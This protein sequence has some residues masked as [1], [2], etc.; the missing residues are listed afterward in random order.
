MFYLFLLFPANQSLAGKLVLPWPA[1]SS[2]SYTGRRARLKTS[3][4][5]ISCI[6]LFSYL[7][8][9]LPSL[10]LLLFPFNGCLL[11]RLLQQIKPKGIRA[12]SIP[13]FATLP[14][15]I[16]WPADKQGCLTRPGQTGFTGEL[17]LSSEQ[18]FL[19][20]HG[21]LWPETDQRLKLVRRLSL[22]FS[23]DELALSLD[24]PSQSPPG[25]RG[26]ESYWLL[27]HFAYISTK[28][29]FHFCTTSLTIKICSGLNCVVLCT[30]YYV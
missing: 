15:L 8:F 14:N 13:R 7:F 24:H 30:I 9:L 21:L 25:L 10:L 16:E 1:A 2:S 26:S 23:D 29:R 17:V 19:L 3:P 5:L 18:A 12:A 22:S 20:S 6:W 27:W 28:L 4:S 11:S